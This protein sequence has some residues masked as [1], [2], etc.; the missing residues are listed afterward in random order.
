MAKDAYYFRHDA[1][2][3][4]D[5]KIQMMMSKYGPSGYGW[6][7]IV[8]ETMRSENGYKILDKPFNW[9]ALAVKSRT[10]PE[11][12]KEFIDDCVKEYELFSYEKLNGCRFLF[13]SSF[14]GRMAKLDNM[15]DQRS[16]AAYAMHEKAGHYD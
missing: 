6:F 11:K 16:K 1:H 10:T 2:A 7:W 5:P 8:I 15:R 3:V 4:D 12:I 13:S 14:L 9:N